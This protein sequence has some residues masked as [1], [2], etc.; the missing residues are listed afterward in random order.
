MRVLELYHFGIKGMR[1]GVR[2]NKNKMDGAS[3]DAKAAA[4]AKAK[5]K[6][7]GVK[8]LN[9]KE[10]QALVKR[11]NLEQQFS[12]MKP[13]PKAKIAAKFVTDVLVGVGKTQATRLAN[14][15]A[16]RQLARLLKK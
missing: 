12:A 7:G 13:P 4:D 8:A 11:M 16:A 3:D 6:K 5:V 9:N 2:R 10:L 14:D 15:E 1:W